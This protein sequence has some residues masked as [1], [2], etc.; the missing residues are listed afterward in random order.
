MPPSR[1]KSLPS[2]A[3][4]LH[5]N[6]RIVFLLFF[7]FACENP[8]FCFRQ[9]TNKTHIILFQAFYV[10]LIF[11]PHLFFLPSFFFPSLPSSEGGWSPRLHSRFVGVSLG[12][13]EAW[14]HNIKCV[15][16]R[17]LLPS[18]TTT[19]HKITRR[20]MENVEFNVFVHRGLGGKEDPC[21]QSFVLLAPMLDVF[22]R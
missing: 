7:F 21:P 12:A 6:H 18:S 19:T 1:W 22:R 11:S 8:L 4:P 9:H 20:F 15:N 10:V 2:L 5:R 14:H 13:N 3:P 16:I 17:C